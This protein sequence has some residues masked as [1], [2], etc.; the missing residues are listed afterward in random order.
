MFTHSIHFTSQVFRPYKLK[1]LDAHPVKSSVEEVGRREPGCN[2]I[3]TICFY[4]NTTFKHNTLLSKAP[5]HTWKIQ[6]RKV[7]KYNY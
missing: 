4:H 5:D 6:K 2:A 3:S 7:R 1:S